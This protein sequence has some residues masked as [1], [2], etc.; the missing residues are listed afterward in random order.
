[1]RTVQCVD[2]SNGGRVADDALCLNSTGGGGARSLGG[3]GGSRNRRRRRRRRKR[4]DGASISRRKHKPKVSRTCNRLPCPF[5]WEPGQ[6]S[7]VR[8]FTR[9][10]LT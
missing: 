1:M 9:V 10:V 4:K 2:I 6:W 7:A 3:G 8:S 5:K